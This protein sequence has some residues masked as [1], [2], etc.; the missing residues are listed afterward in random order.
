MFTLKL[1]AD[2]LHSLYSYCRCDFYNYGRNTSCLRC[3]CKCPREVP[4]SLAA[5]GVGLPYNKSSTVQAD[6]FRASDLSGVE[7]NAVSVSSIS[8]S[9]DSIIG[10]SSTTS[11]I[12]RRLVSSE[13][14]NGTG[15]SS[16]QSERIRTQRRDP[17]YVPFVPLPSDMF[18]N[19]QKSN[20]DLRQSSLE[21]D[22]SS[23]MGTD[24]MSDPTVKK[25]ERMVENNDKDSSDMAEKWSKKVAELDDASDLANSV[26][27]DDFPEIMP[28]RKGENRFVISKKKDRSLTSPQYKRRIAL[29]QAS[30][31]NYVPFVPF[32]PGYFAKKD[33]QPETSTKD[34]PSGPVTDEKA[35]TVPEKSDENMTE[36]SNLVSSGNATLLP[37]TKATSQSNNS[38]PSSAN[39]SGDNIKGSKVGSVYDIAATTSVGSPGNS[40][41]N[42][43]KNRNNEHNSSAHGVDNAT[44]KVQQSESSQIAE[45]RKPSL[46]G[47]SLEGSLVKEPDPLDMSEEAKAARWFRRVAQIKDISELNNIPDEDFPE[48]MPMRKGVNRFVV[49]KR[50]TPLER[51]LTSSRYTKN[52][53]VINS[54]PDKDAS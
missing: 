49:S 48:I 12:R 22:S 39:S 4:P 25:S 36:A 2:Y 6:S 40:W 35:Q 20:N 43:N 29:E 34:S 13:R 27:D 30:T 26:S 42:N 8:K 24:R 14:D 23:P 51:R 46:G 3:D 31:S 11:G 18:N 32:P 47:K 44:A 19:S 50:K 16:E 54:D 38:K 52:L 5:S 15:S 41:T 28:M 45:E 37:E 33:T 21:Q 7:P 10:R 17:D 9:L 1:F 53:P